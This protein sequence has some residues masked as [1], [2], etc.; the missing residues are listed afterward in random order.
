M[1]SHLKFDFDLF[2]IGAGSAGVRA[3]RMCAASG[4]KVAVAEDLYLG[5]TCVNVGC[6]PK[7]LL[8]YA[9]HFS[10]DMKDARGYGWKIIPGEFNWQ[11]LISNKNIEIG[12]L[13]NIYQRLLDDA[14]VT[15]IKGRA[16]VRDPHT[17][18]VGDTH[19]STG[20]ILVATGGWPSIP[21]IAGR[22]YI[23]SSNEAFYLEALPER[24]II[25]GGGYIAVEFAGIFNGLGAETSLVYRGPLFLRG[26]DDECRLQLA[27]E[28]KKKGIEL[29]FNRNIESI[30]KRENSLVAHFNTGESK[31]ADL[32]MYA[33]GRKPN[34]AGLGLQECGVKLNENGAVIVDEYYQTSVP[35]MFAI[36]DVTDRMNLTPVAIAEGMALAQTLFGDKPVKV[37]YMNIPTCIF[38]QPNYATVGLT[39][40]QAREQYSTLEVYKSTFTQLKNTLS[41]N[42]EKVFM[43]LIVD[44]TSDRV[45]GVHMIGPDAGEIIQGIAVAMK[46]GATKAH[47][48]ATIG[49]HP[50]VAEEFV[51]MRK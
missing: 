16:L 5:G 27:E 32:I 28:L 12:R 42:Q 30:E 47:F 41:G 48:D 31:E 37:D 6:V 43:K 4:A 13:N 9:S 25:A 1:I 50:T 15:T 24:I 46:A 36:G 26:F 51:T 14:G 40:E 22:E 34:T 39:E 33:T 7:K 29:I 19:Y 23:I 44:N 21:D 3:A 20:R 17:V 35:S 18:S 8:V 45:I 11:E 10:E 38:S 2:V 49:I